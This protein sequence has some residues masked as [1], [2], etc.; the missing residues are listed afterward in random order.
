[1]AGALWFVTI[2]LAGYTY[3]FTNPGDA[4][5]PYRAVSYWWSQ[6]SIQRI[7]GPWFFHLVRLCLYEFLP[8]LA[9]L[10]WVARRWR[11]L[12]DWEVFCLFWAL[13]A[14]VM[15]A[16]LGEKVPWLLVHQVL[17][18]FPLAGAQLA[19][20]FS[21]R[22]AVWSRGLASV[23]LLATV[24]SAWNVTFRTPALTPGQ[25]RAELLVFV[26]TTPALGAVARQGRHLHRERPGQVV[27]AVSGEASWP[28]SWQWRRIPVVWGLPGEGVA[29]PLV[30]CDPHLAEQILDRLPPG[31]SRRSLPLRGWWVEEWKGV[32]PRTLARWFFTRRPW[33][34]LG[35]TETVVLELNGRSFDK[36]VNP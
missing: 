5:F 33:S 6:H 32:T 8:A 7:P 10:I 2:T 27:A 26:Q 16:Y 29:P 11:R 28:L 34:P 18:L 25:D 14:F 19:R 12:R 1:V 3:F 21:P 30:V 4:F 31:Y 23:A 13:S 35:A 17:P 20:T 9:G 24:W 15:Y 36:G 22:G